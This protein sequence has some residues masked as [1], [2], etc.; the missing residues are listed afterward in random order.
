MKMLLDVY[1]TCIDRA[2]NSREKKKP[3]QK[4]VTAS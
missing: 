4:F 2:D 1:S 3:E